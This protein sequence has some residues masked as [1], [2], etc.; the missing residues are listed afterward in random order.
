MTGIQYGFKILNIHTQLLGLRAR[1]HIY[2]VTVCNKE[3][4]L[5]KKTYNLFIYLSV[6]L[7]T[8]KAR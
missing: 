6:Y 7:S 3:I 5:K 1:Y 8:V 4:L 2:M